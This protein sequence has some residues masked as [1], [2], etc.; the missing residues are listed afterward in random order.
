MFLCR[1]TNMLDYNLPK[2][3]LGL[4]CHIWYKYSEM[5]LKPGSSQA[6]KQLWVLLKILTILSLH[7]I[8]MGEG[9][10]SI[11]NEKWSL[12]LGPNREV[13]ETDKNE[14]KKTSECSELT[15]MNPLLSS[16]SE[17]WH[18]SKG[19]WKGE[20]DMHAC[21]LRHCLNITDWDAKSL[22]FHLLKVVES[23]FLLK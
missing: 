18:G 12:G 4:K 5:S 2:A 14:G 19:P 10:E 6:V 8:L 20:L 22:V 21:D 16:M 13:W 11:K 15:L 1:N 9:Q 23:D 7:M 3:Y 17:Y